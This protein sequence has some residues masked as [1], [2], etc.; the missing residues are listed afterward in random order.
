MMN[1]PAPTNKIK[2]C[3]EALQRRLPSLER[4]VVNDRTVHVW[5][6]YWIDKCTHREIAVEQGWSVPAVNW[7]LR[8]A[9]RVLDAV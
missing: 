1:T 8:R 9:E 7:H 4:S 3:L 6:R 5:T 2:G